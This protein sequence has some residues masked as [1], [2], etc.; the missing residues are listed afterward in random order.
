M[1]TLNFVVNKR[2]HRTFSLSIVEYRAQPTAVWMHRKG[3]ITRDSSRCAP[4]HFLDA[5]TS[6]SVETNGALRGEGSVGVSLNIVE[7]IMMKLEHVESQ[8]K[9]VKG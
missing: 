1:G 6:I 9:L 8:A 5:A 3:L 7:G 2:T 4:M